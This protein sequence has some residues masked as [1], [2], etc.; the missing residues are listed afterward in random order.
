MTGSAK[1][2]IFDRGSSSLSSVIRH[3]FATKIAFSRSVDGP[4]GL[5]RLQGASSD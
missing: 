2:S 5:Q 1:Q 3:T 4:S